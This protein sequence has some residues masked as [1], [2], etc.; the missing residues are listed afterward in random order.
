MTAPR[1]RAIPERS[2]TTTP[3]TTERY[4]SADFL[5]REIECVFRRTWIVVGRESDIPRPGSC[6]PVDELGQSLLLVR[7]TDG[8]VR[9]FHNTCRHRGTRLLSRRCTG[10]RITCPYH[11]WT[12]ALDGRLIG[13]PDAQGF[14]HLDK[15]ERGLVPVRAECWGGFVWVTFDP[16][17]SPL[18]HFLGA[19][20]SQLDGYRL[21]DMRPLARRSWTL[22][23]N[24]KAVL[25][26]AAESYHIRDVHGQSIGRVMDA[27][28]EFHALYPHQLLTIPIAD[29]GWRGW[30]DRASA[31]SDLSFTPD[32]LRLFH[33]YVIFPNTLINVLP[34]HLTVFR[35]VPLT[36]GTCRFHYEFHVREH[37]GVVA[38]TRGWLTLLASLYILREDFRVLRSFQSGLETGAPRPISFHRDEHALEYFQGVLSD[39]VD[40]GA[41]PSA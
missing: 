4:T 16:D 26:N 30:L 41:A 20:A 15:S 21:A 34:Y 19:V 3:C 17:P 35:V 6:L 5:A 24:W 13:V 12:Y 32:Q 37:A 25:D 8:T 36:P 40:G 38:R 31:P 39:Y 1:D 7:G 27:C 11:G 14:S 10:P 2:A 29:Y 23:C 22:Q 9:A 33:K 28:F 18:R